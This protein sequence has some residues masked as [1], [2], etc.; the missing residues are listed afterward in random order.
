[1]SL[2]TGRGP[3]GPNPAGR[4]SIPVPTGVVYVEPFARRV[5]GVLRGLV[6][7]DSERAVLVHRPGHP[8]AYAFPSDDVEVEAAVADPDAPG[9]VRVPWDAVDEW[10]EE[11]ERVSGHP[12]NPYHRVDCVRTARHLRVE[13]A[14]LVL[15]DTTDTMGVYEAALAPKLYVRKDLVRPDVLVPSATTTY[16]PYKGTASYWSAVVD[17]ATVDDVAWTYE[18]PLPECEPIRGLVSFEVDRVSVQHDLPT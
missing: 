2:T 3:L 7:V 8:P 9:C 18:D 4:F 17:G 5:R 12:R 11:E 13:V 15:V 1:V 10:F 14:G 16:C 6:V